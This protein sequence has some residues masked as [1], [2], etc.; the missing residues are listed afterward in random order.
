MSDGLVITGSTPRIRGCKIEV[1]ASIRDLPIGVAQEDTPRSTA[2]MV[3]VVDWINANYDYY[4]KWGGFEVIYDDI[5]TV[6]QDYIKG[7]E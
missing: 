3:E 6:I 5:I 1:I 7:G 4:N 2:Y